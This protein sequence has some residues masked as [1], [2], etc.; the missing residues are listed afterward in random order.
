MTYKQS[1][2][3]RPNSV[4]EMFLHVVSMVYTVYWSLWLVTILSRC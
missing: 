2:V 3:R 1:F 4:S